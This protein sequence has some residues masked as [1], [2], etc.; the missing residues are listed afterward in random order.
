MNSHQSNNGN[1]NSGANQFFA[2]Q[3]ELHSS[4]N[5]CPNISG[6]L[7]FRSHGRPLAALWRP[8]RTY[9][10]LLPMWYGRHRS[11]GF[12]GRRRRTNPYPAVLLMGPSWLYHSSPLPFTPP[13]KDAEPNQPL[14]WTSSVRTR[15]LSPSNTETRRRYCVRGRAFG[16]CSTPIHEYHVVIIGS[17]A[18]ARTDI[19]SETIW[20]VSGLHNTWLD[21]WGLI[22][23]RDTERPHLLPDKY[24]CLIHRG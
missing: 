20:T 22:P 23:S 21:D 13:G 24:R 6:R 10:A 12:C 2:F 17:L 14:I 5:W 4:R 19:E 11:P 8:Q 15:D 7:S 1:E 18:L 9:R 3:Y 16:T